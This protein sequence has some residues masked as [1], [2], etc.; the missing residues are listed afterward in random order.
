[1][2][3]ESSVKCTDAYTGDRGEV[4]RGDRLIAVSIKVFFNKS[5]VTRLGWERLAP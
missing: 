2:A 1:M 3:F 4:A 5:Y